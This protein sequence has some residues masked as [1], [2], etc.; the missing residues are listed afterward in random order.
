MVP[1][2][3]IPSRKPTV[4]PFRLTAAGAP[5]FKVQ[6]GA[7]VQ[8]CELPSKLPG[9]GTERTV[10]MWSPYPPK[11]TKL[12]KPLNNGGCE[13]W[14][15]GEEFSKTHWSYITMWTM[16]KWICSVLLQIFQ[17]GQQVKTSRH[18]Q[19]SSCNIC[20]VQ[21][22]P[23]LAHLQAGRILWG[24]TAL[25]K[26]SYWGSLIYGNQKKSLYT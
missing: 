1:W 4:P 20:P 3:P 15:F 2:Y 7:K 14:Q 19:K 11:L 12:Q 22:G 5:G 13:L 8:E 23:V 10:V 6:G 18:P 17:G 9:L 26:S 21:I 24:G 16:K 25:R